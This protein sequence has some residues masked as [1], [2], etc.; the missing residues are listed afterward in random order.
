ML[1][2]ELRRGLHCG[3]RISLM[4]EGGASLADFMPHTLFRRVGDLSNYPIDVPAWRFMLTL[5]FSQ[6]LAD[7]EARVK[8]CSV[9]PGN[10]LFRPMLNMFTRLTL[11]PQ[12][13]PPGLRLGY[14]H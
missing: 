11:S 5:G 8:G 7:S 2:L 4:C 10:Y 9:Y 3:K 14:G 13:L 1:E 12:W 6:C